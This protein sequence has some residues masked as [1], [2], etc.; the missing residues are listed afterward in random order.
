MAGPFLEADDLLAYLDQVSE[1]LRQCLLSLPEGALHGPAPG[2][3]DGRT[4]YQLTM[5]ILA[6]CLGHLGEIEALKTMQRYA[7]EKGVRY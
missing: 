4:L 3:Q 5:S 7:K 6:G 1:A 2:F